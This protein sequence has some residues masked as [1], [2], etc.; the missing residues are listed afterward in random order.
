MS[1]PVNETAH[2]LFRA[3]AGDHLAH[4]HLFVHLLQEL[5]RIAQLE[6]FRWHGNETLNATA[7]LHE[8]Y[9]KLLDGATLDVNDR[10]HFLAL[11]GKAMRQVLV[12]YS[13]AKGAQKRGQNPVRVSL[14]DTDL[15]AEE[16]DDPGL[17]ELTWALERLEAEY[18]E[19]SAVVECRF[20]AGMTIEDTAIA[21]GIGETTV[22][23]R[24]GIAKSLLYGILRNGY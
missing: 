5:K 19:L 18:P 14:M 8:A 4:S 6:R 15:F 11:A 1:D 23:R 17:V 12:D 10:A 22:K 13:R 21:L 3:R 16:D 9:L 2:L 20:F 24:W 7:I